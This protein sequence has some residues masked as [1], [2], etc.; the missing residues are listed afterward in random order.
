MRYFD[1]FDQV[2]L[3]GFNPGLKAPLILT[4]I[5][6]LGHDAIIRVQVFSHQ[7]WKTCLIYDQAEGIPKNMLSQE[8]SLNQVLMPN[9]SL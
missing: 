9:C 7:E 3:K 2:I 5:I 6:P 1:Y 8:L 4:N